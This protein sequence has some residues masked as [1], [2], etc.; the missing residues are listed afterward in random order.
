MAEEDLEM[1]RVETDCVESETVTFRSLPLDSV[2][3]SLVPGY[4]MSLGQARVLSVEACRRLEY[5][6]NIFT[7]E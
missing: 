1:F 3:C 2:P 6:E 5:V 4:V 7:A